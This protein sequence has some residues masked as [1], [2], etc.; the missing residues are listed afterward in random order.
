[1]KRKLFLSGAAIALIAANLAYAAPPNNR[2]SAPRPAAPPPA[3]H[4]QTRPIPKPDL[5]PRPPNPQEVRQLQPL[6]P[7]PPR[8][9]GGGAI[10]P[11]GPDSIEA[12]GH[13]TS[14]SGNTTVHGTVG[15]GPG[16]QYGK[17]GVSQGPSGSPDRSEPQE[18]IPEN[19]R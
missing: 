8:T 17:I 16:G 2:A 5:T 4:T 10:Y 14:P 1:M 13:V 12:R 11:T 3:A 19:K 6:P 18:P 7:Q 9:T 15:T